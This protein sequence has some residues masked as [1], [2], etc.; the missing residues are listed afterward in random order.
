MDKHKRGKSF[1]RGRKFDFTCKGASN[2]EPDDNIA[3]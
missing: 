3:S 2:I 1:E